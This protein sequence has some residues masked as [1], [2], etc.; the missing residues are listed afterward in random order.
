MTP[1]TK[2]HLALLA[3]NLIYG[4]NFT[5][6]KHVMPRLIPAFGFIFI[7]VMGS[8]ILFWLLWLMDPG[9]VRIER[10]DWGRFL[11]CGITGITINQ[12]MFFKGLS[13]T[14]PI[15]ASLMQLTS[16]VLITLIAAFLIGERLSWI[17][18]L[19]LVLGIS[20]AALLV[21]MG[22]DVGGG[23]STRLGDFLVFINSFSYATYLVLVKPLMEKYPPLTVIRWVFT[24][25]FPIVSILCWKDFTQI[26]WQAFQTSDW[27]AAAFVVVCTTFLAYLFNAYAL[28][29]LRASTVGAY[30]YLQP[31]FAALIA[32]AFFG[33]HLSAMKILAGAAIFSGVYLV[34]YKKG[35]IDTWRKRWQGSGPEAS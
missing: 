30:I 9:P 1:R 34:G 22:K 11:L 14:L 18:G 4:A 26:R 27:L 13:L 28:G 5:I 31:L 17:K 21:T 29:N 8:V 16:P 6:A 7:R 24:F 19:G 12:M 20:G 33:E 35:R 15:H 25:G 3:A 2:A 23:A 32:M 10:K